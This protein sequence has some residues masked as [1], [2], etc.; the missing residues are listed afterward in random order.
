MKLP[1]DILA[2]ELALVTGAARGNGAAIAQG[3]ARLGARVI[4]TDLVE[5]EAQAVAARIR[6]AG[7]QA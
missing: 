1:N 3:L 2:G 7:G 5:A 4:V 6:D